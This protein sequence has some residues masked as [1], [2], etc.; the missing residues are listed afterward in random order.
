M[1]KVYK[2]FITIKNHKV[3]LLKSGIWVPRSKT[4]LF[5]I[6]PTAY[7]VRN[8]WDT[9]YYPIIPEEKST[10]LACYTSEK[11][12]GSIPLLNYPVIFRSFRIILDHGRQLFT[13][14]ENK[15]LYRGLYLIPCNKPYGKEKKI[16]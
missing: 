10:C 13:L 8:L 9:F 11:S 7:A 4:K 15:N 16:Y 12:L 5:L 3:I 14:S 1:R 6:V 2:S